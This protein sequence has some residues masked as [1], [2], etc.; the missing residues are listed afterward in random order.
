MIK[1][2]VAEIPEHEKKMNLH[3]G[4]RDRREEIASS[5]NSSSRS[6][7]LIVSDVASQ[8]CCVSSWLRVNAFG[9]IRPFRYKYIYKYGFALCVIG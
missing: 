6:F 3:V 1:A 2:S 5:S 7:A 9:A 4:Q 8:R